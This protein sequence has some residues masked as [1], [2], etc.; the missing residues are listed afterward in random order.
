[1]SPCFWIQYRK[2]NI[3]EIE[4]CVKTVYISD[5]QKTVRFCFELSGPTSPF[6]EEECSL[7]LGTD[8][9]E[10]EEYFHRQ[11][12]EIFH[13]RQERID[14]MFSAYP[15]YISL[16]DLKIIFPKC[17]SIELHRTKQFD[18]S[19]LAIFTN[20]RSFTLNS[21]VQK[22]LNGIE[23]L[24]SLCEFYMYGDIRK[25]RIDLTQLNCLKLKKLTLVILEQHLK[26]LNIET[27]EHLTLNLPYLLSVENVKLPNL[28][29]LIMGVREYYPLPEIKIPTGLIIPDE[30]VRSQATATYIYNYDF[31]LDTQYIPR[32]VIESY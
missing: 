12:V 4:K 8:G 23:F 29:S 21:N 24:E 11:R 18:V 30:C 1:M 5:N 27:L 14:N 2:N 20:L 6:Y 19:S 16:E 9:N 32:P 10:L 22:N 26:N 17:S 28:K 25:T 15:N 13:D 7:H 3:E 31:R